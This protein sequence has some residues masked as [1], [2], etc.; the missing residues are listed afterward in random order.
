MQRLSA[1]LCPG[2]DFFRELKSDGDLRLGSVR[3][4]EL[5]LLLLLKPL[6]PAATRQFGGLSLQA[7]LFTPQ[8]SVQLVELD[9]QIRKG[10][11]I[12]G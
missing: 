8:H 10:G 5:L 3:V 1:H 2:E 11:A 9:F 6:A 7:R 4:L 12:L